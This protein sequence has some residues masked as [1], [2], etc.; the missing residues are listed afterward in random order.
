MLTDC[1]EHFLRYFNQFIFKNVYLSLCFID[2]VVIMRIGYIVLVACFLAQILISK[3]FHW[4]SWNACLVADMAI[5][6][7]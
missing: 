3:M 1:S 2:F 5:L 6:P 7:K 4:L